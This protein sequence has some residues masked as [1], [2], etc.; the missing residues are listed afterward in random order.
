MNNFHFHADLDDPGALAASVAGVT[1]HG[2]VR[3]LRGWQAGAR[4]D[5]RIAVE[6]EYGPVNV[7]W[8]RRKG[9]FSLDVHVFGHGL[10]VR[11]TEAR[12]CRAMARALGRA[13]LFS[14][15][16]ANPFSYFLAEP[17]GS[18]WRAYIAVLDDLDIVDLV[19]L[20]A[21]NRAALEPALI[22]AAGANLP[23]LPEDVTPDTRYRSCDMVEPRPGIVDLCQN[24]GMPCPQLTLAALRRGR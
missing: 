5:G 13:L 4:G 15:C 3:L 6:E 1:G 17:D 19:E 2:D 8:L 23:L 18:L 20:D 12:F 10:A 24:F 7:E 21:D 9:R 16:G 14:D 22:A 11:E